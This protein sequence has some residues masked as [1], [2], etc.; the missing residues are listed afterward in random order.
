ME[1]YLLQ[2]Y[3]AEGLEILK[4]PPLLSTIRINTLKI[5]KTEAYEYL[6]SLFNSLEIHSNPSMPDVFF[7]SSLGPFTRTIHEKCVFVDY[8]CGEAVLRGAHVYSPGILGSNQN[9]EVYTVNK[10]DEISVFAVKNCFTRGLKLLLD[11]TQERVFLGNGVSRMFR[12]DV[13]SINKGLAVEMTQA[14]YLMPNFD[15]LP[16]NLFYPQNLGSSVVGHI[17]NVSC[18]KAFA[19]RIY[20]RHVCSPRRKNYSYSNFD[21]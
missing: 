15:K 8:K 18:I 19:W 14:N 21:E 1:D 6:Q 13:F 3:S 16:K 17:L 5:S 12:K 11:Q 4:T 20:F 2:K 10:D 7:I 9:C